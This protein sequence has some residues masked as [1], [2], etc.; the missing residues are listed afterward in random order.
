M[1]RWVKTLINTPAKD[2]NSAAGIVDVLDTASVE[3][4]HNSKPSA[5]NIEVLKEY[6]EYLRY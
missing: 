5:H 1:Y 6:K 3:T 4:P 2:R